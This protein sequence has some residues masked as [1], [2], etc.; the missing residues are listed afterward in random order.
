MRVLFTLFAAIALTVG[1]STASAGKGKG[2]N[3]AAAHACHHGGYQNFVRAD[4]TSFKNTGACVSYAAHGGTLVAKSQSQLDCESF[5]GTFGTENLTNG[6]GTVIWSCNGWVFTSPDY[7][8]L[9]NDCVAA[10]GG[11][12]AENPAAT[13]GRAN[14]TC[15]AP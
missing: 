8:V 12:F 10:G 3:S 2:G 11:G 1:V 7:N 13:P 15:F 4:G 14:F 9:I 5:G 6:V